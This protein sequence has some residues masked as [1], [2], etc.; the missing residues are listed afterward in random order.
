MGPDDL[1]PIQESV[2]QLETDIK[3]L[4]NA[5]TTWD[6]DSLNSSGSKMY[7]GIVRRIVLQA[8]KVEALVKQKT[9]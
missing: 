3:E 9:F 1:Q 8:E 7:K 6:K 2:R 4:K 5:L